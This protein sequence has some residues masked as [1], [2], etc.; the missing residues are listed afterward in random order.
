MKIKIAIVDSRIGE[1]MERALTLRGFRVITLPRFSRLSEAVSSHTDM[2]ICRIGE[3]YISYADYCD[4][5]AYV[6]TDLSVLLAPSG[7]KFSFTSDE[8]S[9]DYPNDCRL[10]A[11]M[12]GDKLFC[13]TDS[14]SEYLLKRAEAARISA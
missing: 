9:A 4:E 14:E 6:F 10:N 11:L 5:A 3:E 1:T 8:V 2:L 13:R 12:M 7:A